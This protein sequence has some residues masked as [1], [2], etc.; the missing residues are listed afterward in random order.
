M[1]VRADLGSFFV[2]AVVAIAARRALMH[3]DRAA[4]VSA[5]PGVASAGELP[6]VVPVLTIH[7]DEIA[8]HDARWLEVAERNNWSAAARTMQFG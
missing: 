8:G 1:T 5:T 3:R 2:L 6:I 7:E 4:A